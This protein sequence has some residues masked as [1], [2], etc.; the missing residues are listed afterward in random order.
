MAGNNKDRYG[1]R[2]RK[3]SNYGVGESMPGDVGDS[4][5]TFHDRARKNS[6]VIVDGEVRSVRSHRRE[7]A[8]NVS[9]SSNSNTSRSVRTGSSISQK[10]AAGK[11]V[12]VTVNSRGGTL[13]NLAQYRNH[14]V[15]VEG[16]EP[17]ETIQ[18]ELEAGS[19]FLIGRKVRSKE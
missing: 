10:Q 13:D 18:V 15:H 11:T 6:N 5:G 3:D 1:Y 8:E 12:M 17:G 14:Q 19:G 7:S 16:G 9:Q 2:H 4:Q